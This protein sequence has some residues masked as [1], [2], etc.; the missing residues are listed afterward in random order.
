MNKK[1]MEAIATVVLSSVLIS[2]PIAAL[3]LI[4]HLIIS[5]Q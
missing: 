1:T 2:L 3:A 5:G 4:E